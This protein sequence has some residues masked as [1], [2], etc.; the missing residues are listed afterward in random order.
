MRWIKAMIGLITVIWMVPQSSIAA[1][2]DGSVPLLCS[3]T[4]ISECTSGGDCFPVT[5]ET[6]NIPPFLKIDFTA[7]TISATEESGRQEVTTINNIE[8]LDGKI[9]LQ[10]AENGR[11]WTIVISEKTGKL[12]ATVSDD[13][14]GFVV[15][16]AST[17]F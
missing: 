7:N 17:P 9:I 10:G 11:G 6:A 1:G 13:Q 14:V 16:G 3:V 5:A 12:S 15:F 8:H 4:Q 2:F